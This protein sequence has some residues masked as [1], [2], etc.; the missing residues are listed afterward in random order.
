MPTGVCDLDIIYS[1]YCTH[2]SMYP[3]SQ[4]ALPR[5]RTGSTPVTPKEENDQRNKKERKKKKE[6]PKIENRFASTQGYI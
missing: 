2:L 5:G 1:T 3:S 4:G 6:K